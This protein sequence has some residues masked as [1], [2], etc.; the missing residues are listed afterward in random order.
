M[1]KRIFSFVLVV[2]LV[3]ACVTFVACDSTPKLKVTFDRAN[4]EK[5]YT[6]TVK[7]G[8]SID[9]PE[10]PT[11]GDR[12]F[13]AW[14]NG[15]DRISFPYTPTEDVTLTA[16]WSLDGIVYNRFYSSSNDRDEY[17][18][19]NAQLSN[20]KNVI[21]PNEVDGIPVTT[22]ASK[23]FSQSNA[24][25]EIPSSITSI[26]S[27]SFGT[28][29]KIIWHYNDNINS[30][31]LQTLT[32]KVIFSKQYSVVPERALA[33]F[34]TLQS[35][36]LA[37]NTTKISDSAFY[38]CS[39]LEYVYLPNTIT[40]IGESAFGCPDDTQ[41]N[42]YSSTLTINGLPTNL[43]YIGDHAFN[44]CRLL[45]IVSVPASVEYIGEGAFRNCK[46][47][48]NVRI[49]ANI[50][51]LNDNVFYQCKNL[52]SIILPNGLVNIGDSAFRACENLYNVLLPDSLIDI[53]DN[54]FR[55]CKSLQDIQLPN[56]LK[57]IGKYSFAASALA[58]II[59]PDT[60]ESIGASAFAS[61]DILSVIIPLSVTS[62]GTSIFEWC[63]G[64]LVILCEAE[65]AMPGWHTRWN[66]PYPMSGKFETIFGYSG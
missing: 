44:N 45:D 64:K 19:I 37:E 60:L 59:L 5:T 54:A 56:S 51:S 1:K 63:N 23:A 8:F 32:I 33:G 62:I 22:I 38:N 24:I 57:S 65:S 18:I 52:K 48:S 26:A 12:T 20:Q 36:E 42:T 66:A 3:V 9:E 40:Y 13:Y 16:V 14:Y 28:D 7:E 34:K 47:I 43:K 61:T 46:S 31:V 6:K 58:Y 15:N 4:G 50:S 39:K 53:G 55:G 17:S 11:Y 2:I 29:C 25:F 30:T 35:I 41:I 27:G 49:D 21:I 10:V